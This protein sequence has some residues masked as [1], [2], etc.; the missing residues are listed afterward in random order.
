[1]GR[2]WCACAAPRGVER[3][4]LKWFVWAAAVAALGNSPLGWWFT[5]GIAPS[6]SLWI[7]PAAIGVAVIRY[8]LY[9][10]DRVISRSLTYGLLTVLLGLV[11]IGGVFALGQVLNP[12]GESAL[13]VAASTL[14]VAALFQPARRRV[15]AAVDRRFN[16]RRHDSATTMEAFSR[17]MRDQV[18][19]DTLTAELLAV[20]NQT[21]E[22]RRVSLWLRPIRPTPRPA[23]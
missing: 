8:R 15:Q 11:Y 17:H 6:L 19:L 7:I 21:M 2:W 18:D 1:L 10:I 13:A 16:R 5:L 4:Q 20:V 12:S 14:A 23:R 22:P 3:Q 9:D